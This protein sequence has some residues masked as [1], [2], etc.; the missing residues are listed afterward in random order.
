M[1]SSHPRFMEYSE[2]EKILNTSTSESDKVNAIVRKSKSVPS[3]TSMVDGGIAFAHY[4]LTGNEFL[5]QCTGAVPGTRDYN[6]QH[7]KSSSVT[8]TRRKPDL[9]LECGIPPI[10]RLINHPGQSILLPRICD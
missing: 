9:W 8:S 7:C 2:L 10:A 5:R 6:K 1:G 3:L 4:C